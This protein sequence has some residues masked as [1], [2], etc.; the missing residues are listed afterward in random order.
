MQIKSIPYMRALCQPFSSAFPAFPEESLAK[1][2]QSGGAL[3]SAHHSTARAA[4]GRLPR[5][6]RARLRGRAGRLWVSPLLRPCTGTGRTVFCVRPCCGRARGKALLTLGLSTPQSRLP[7]RQLPLHRGAF[8]AR[9]AL[10]TTRRG[11]QA[12][13]AV[14]V[15]PFINSSLPREAG[16][17]AVRAPASGECPVRGGLGGRMPPISK[18]TLPLYRRG[19]VAEVSAASG[20]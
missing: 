17:R 2:F 14:F 13:T 9:P 19:G 6:G 1:N 20:G 10:R 5:Y 7:P 15:L 11:K 18:S 3:P 8:G 16:P 12:R 4:F